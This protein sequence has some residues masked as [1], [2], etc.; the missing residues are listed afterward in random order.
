MYKARGKRFWGLA[1]L[2]AGMLLAG[3][4]GAWYGLPWYRPYGSGAMTYERQSMMR[5]HGYSMHDLSAMFDGRRAFN[6]EEAVILANELEEGFGANLV[7]NYAPGSMVAGSRTVP[8]T[9]RNF[10]LFQG[11]AEAARQ[12]SSGLADALATPPTG[13]EVRQQGVWVTEPR[14]LH[15]RGRLMS[16][17]LVSM[18]AIREYDRLNA[19]CYSCHVLFRGWRW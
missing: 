5:G 7:R 17:G 2:S 19:T 9:W 6:R 8:W 15:G 10:G 4:A 1:A 3:T 11:Y 13:E 18:E 16:D 12:A 14:M